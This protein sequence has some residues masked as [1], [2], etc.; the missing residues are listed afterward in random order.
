MEV[1]GGIVVVENPSPLLPQFWSHATH[2]I[3]QVQIRGA[4]FHGSQKK[5]QH[6]FDFLVG[7][8]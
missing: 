1:C 4:Q 7:F 8:L 5:H 6:G 2:T 3:P